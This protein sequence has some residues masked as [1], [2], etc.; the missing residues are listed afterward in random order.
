MALWIFCMESLVD[1]EMLVLQGKDL[2]AMD[3][4]ECCIVSSM[5]SD[6]HTISPPLQQCIKS[7]D[8]HLTV[9]DPSYRSETTAS[10]CIYISRR[11]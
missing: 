1:S 6:H 9:T 3:V 11:H 7:K 5:I 10:L 4:R 8:K 2:I